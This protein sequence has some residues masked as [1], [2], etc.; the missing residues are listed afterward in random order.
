MTSSVIDD[1]SNVAGG[2]STPVF[3]NTSLNAL[4]FAV[5]LAIFF[6]LKERLQESQICRKR[7]V[8]IGV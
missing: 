3:V 8:L 7:I 5:D 2:E 1:T 6:L 4:L